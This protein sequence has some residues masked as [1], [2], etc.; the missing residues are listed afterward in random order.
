MQQHF[1]KIFSPTTTATATAF[2]P[3]GIPS[4]SGFDL[5]PFSDTEVHAAIRSLATGKAT[6]L[7]NVPN[8]A[9]KCP[10]LQS[11]LRDLVNEVTDEVSPAHTYS[12]LR[13]TSS[14]ISRSAQ[15]LSST[16]GVNVCALVT[17]QAA[18]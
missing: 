4:L 17:S 11:I 10:E 3:D 5:Q 9:L 18:E 1:A 12:S 16:K 14:K 13:F 7:D 8:E 6:G 15:S 2:V